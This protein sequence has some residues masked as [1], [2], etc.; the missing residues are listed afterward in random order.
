MAGYKYIKRADGILV[1]GVRVVKPI[2]R[3]ERDEL[4]LAGKELDGR[5]LKAATDKFKPS[6]ADGEVFSAT[7]GHRGERI[8]RIL[9]Q[10]VVQHNGAPTAELDI[11]LVDKKAQDD[12]MNGLLP[13]IS[14]DIDLD[15]E[16]IYAVSLLDKGHGHFG[17]DEL[18]THFFPADMQLAL[19]KAGENHVCIKC[20][21]APPAEDTT[22]ELTAENLKA[23]ADAL[24]PV[25]ESAVDAKI[26][27]VLELTKKVNTDPADP[28]NDVVRANERSKLMLE[29]KDAE[30]KLAL[31][32]E[33]DISNKL[34]EA[35]EVDVG[36]NIQAVRLQL[37]KRSPGRDAA[38][39]QQARDDYMRLLLDR[40]KTGR[41]LVIGTD[42]PD[43]KG[44]DKTTLELERAYD[45]QA[46]NWKAIGITKDEYI[47]RR[48]RKRTERQTVAA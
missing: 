46:E 4:K 26:A 8:G 35:A 33:K 15:E 12:W 20:E 36:V 1:P 2:T 44:K 11:L 32:T 25:I 17:K 24:R 18:G 28:A 40:A 45:A 9:G 13:E 39:E 30:H 7:R 34:A 10:R 37:E 48:L 6:A 14:A 19:S 22:M 43:E 3:G 23:I 21:P 16:K 42:D 38:L 5:F 41:Q 29:A 31:A 47:E 27:P